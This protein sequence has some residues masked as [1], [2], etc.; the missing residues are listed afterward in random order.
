[1]KEDLDRE[2]RAIQK[3]WA[4]R[5]KQIEKVL[6]NTAGMYGDL[7]QGLVG[8]N[9]LRIEPLEMGKLGEREEGR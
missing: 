6:A 8:A 7:Q 4:A 5:E 3:Q 1:M 9:M 2:K